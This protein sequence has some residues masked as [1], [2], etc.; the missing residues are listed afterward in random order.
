MGVARRHLLAGAA[1]SAIVAASGA[2][3][4]LRFVRAAQANIYGESAPF[5]R[6]RLRAAAEALSHQPYVDRRKDVPQALLDISYTAY[7]NIRMGDG[8]P[9][10]LSEDGH[11]VYEAL[12]G[13]FV[14]NQPVDLWVVE[15]DSAR[16]VIFDRANFRFD[17]PA[18]T[19]V[20]AGPLPFSG[21]RLRTEM[22][23]PGL[24]SE[25]IVF[26]GASY[27]RA[28]GIGETYGLS[29][30]GLAIDTGAATGEEFP[31]F[32]SFWIEKAGNDAKAVTVHALLDSPSTTGIYRIT[33]RP[34]DATV[35]DVELT[36]FPRREIDKIGFAP[37]SSM[38]LFDGMNRN[39]FDDYRNAVHD[40]DGL[41]IHT[42]SGEW[43]WRPLNNHRLLQVSGFVDNGP[44]GFGLIQRKRKYEDYLDA[45]ARY[46]T[47]PTAWVE[48]IGNW[49]EGS[50]V[51][52]EIPTDAETNDNI[53]AYWQ[54]ANPIAAGQPYDVTYRIHWDALPPTQ[55]DGPRIAMTRQGRN[56]SGNRRL[57][58]ID[59]EMNGA[60]LDGATAE[61]RASAGKVMNMTQYPVPEPGIL[62]VSFEL[63]TD[64]EDLIEIR[65]T[66][67]PKE[68]PQAER[69]LYRWTS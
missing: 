51:L 43:I 63:D 31:V 19:E 4:S 40:S 8:W 10:N 29:A 39:A 47:R 20:P 5:S 16:R 3:P 55:S 61:V 56:F 67:S 36:L 59:Y 62:R 57:F 48:P 11:F 32:R 18:D 53:V 1:A 60:P 68:G 34:G 9:A 45:E 21:F 41:S 64:G 2:I 15:G 58:V 35:S 22:G 38:F 6:E 54:P 66:M 69:W 44:R 14:F 49:G 37:F 52:F 46:E 30:R 50:V 13:G 65:M 26:Q 25:F 27:F 33:T 12:P 24:L 23:E 28:I 7:R 42:G 17:P